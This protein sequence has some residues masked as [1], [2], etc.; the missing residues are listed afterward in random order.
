MQLR[1]LTS[2]ARRLFR[3]AG[4]LL[5]ALGS[6]RRPS[7][8][9]T[10]LL[11]P[12]LATLALASCGEIP[13]VRSIMPFPG[14]PDLVVGFVADT[15][16]QNQRAWAARNLLRN[17]MSDKVI[18]VT[19]RPPTLD[20]TARVLLRSHL[21]LQKEKG[22]SAIFYLGDGSNHGC[23]SELSAETKGEE[24][25]FPLLSRFRE[26]RDVPVFFVLGNH[27]FLA[28]GN[29]EERESHADLC[30]GEE[31]VATKRELI[32]LADAFNR[33][34]AD[35][36]R[37]T[38]A[39]S[40]DGA[41]SANCQTPVAAPQSRRRSCYYAATLD[42]PA[43]GRTFRFLL[44]DTNDYVD[45]TRSRA[46]PSR[47]RGL[48][49][50]DFEGQ[51]GAMS[52]VDEARALSQTSWLGARGKAAAAAGSTPTVLVALSHYD[53]GALSKTFVIPLSRQVQRLA[54]I[55]ADG[56]TRFYQ[57]SSFFVSA[58]TH[59]PIT[60]RISRGIIENGVEIVRLEELNIGSTTDYPSLSAVA[61][62]GR[63]WSGATMSYEPLTP[64]RGRCG[65][66]MRELEETDFPN[67]VLGARRGRQ[68]VALSKERPD[69]YQYI[70]DAAEAK[71]IFDNIAHFVN[72]SEER[73]ICL[74][75]EG[76]ALEADKDSER[77]AL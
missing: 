3:A 29:T 17:R 48:L 26:E 73:A 22:V 54:D 62:F 25:I 60:D 63:N 53:V 56:D 38:Y 41:G 66:L 47:G 28:A 51:R 76:G 75:L 24:G 59:T 37:W 14:E 57:E 65:T 46:L 68:A 21:A 15:Q 13:P 30:G 39:S 36:G 77:P 9:K 71:A 10:R 16:I 19:I 33:E 18:E 70:D 31:N 6:D 52:F 4:F 67:V 8:W 2:T 61:R 49:T 20:A 23:R 5:P 55:F 32:R 42:V 74:G 35:K 58:H 27:D 44:L 43:N 69:D 1:P 40:V 50:Q 34:S 12:G 72:G 7:V 11:V 45:V 64:D